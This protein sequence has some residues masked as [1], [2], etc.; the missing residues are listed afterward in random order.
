MNKKSMYA[1]CMA[2]VK[3]LATGM[4]GKCATVKQQVAD[5]VGPLMCALKGLVADQF[6]VGFHKHCV[7]KQTSCSW[8]LSIVPHTCDRGWL[9]ASGFG[10]PCMLL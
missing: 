1:A 5:E 10:M 9:T 8:Q 3:I 4:S 6:M 2:D 7:S